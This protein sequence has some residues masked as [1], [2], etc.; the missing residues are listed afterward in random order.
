MPKLTKAEWLAQLEECGGDMS[1]DQLINL[2]FKDGPNA[3]WQDTI[4]QMHVKHDGIY[5]YLKGLFPM[6]VW[7]D[8]KGTTELGYNYHSPFIPFDASIFQ[9]S[10]LICDPANANECH[11]DYCSIPRGG[12]TNLPEMEMYKAGFK[13]DRI[14]IANIRTSDQAR[15]LAQMFVQERFQ[16]DEQV[17]NIFF[18][19]AVIRMLGHKTVLEYQNNLA[20]TDVELIPN[21]NPYNPLQGGRFNYMEPLFPAAG[22]LENILPLDLRLLDMYGSILDETRDTNNISIGPRG[23]RIYELWYSGDWW[24]TE[25]LDNE[26]YIEKTKYTRTPEILPAHSNNDSS[27]HVIGNFAMRQMSA[28][29]RFAESTEG[30]IS[31]VQ[32]FQ[33]TPVDSGNRATP[34]YREY[35]NAPFRLALMLG[36]DV[37][38]ILSRPDISTGIEGKPIMPITGGVDS[39]WIY[40]NDYDKECNPDLNMP[41]MQKRYEMGFK[42]LNPDAGR[43]W[44]YRAKQFRL[45][46]TQTC[47]LRP[48][49]KIVPASQ[50]CEITTIGCNPLN[51]PLS[52]NIMDDSAGFRQVKCSAVLCG[53]AALRMYRLVIPRA[54]IDSIS[55]DQNPLQSC[56]CGDTVTVFIGD[57]DGDVVKQRDAVIMDYV[58]PNMVQPNPVMIVQLASALTGA[59]CIQSI[60]CKDA[61][62]TLATVVTC[63]DTESDPSIAEGSVKFI[64]NSPIPCGVGDDVE[65]KYYSDADALLDTVVGTIVSINPLTM[66]YV[67]SSEEADWA[68]NFVENT[69]YI[70]VNCD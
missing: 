30:G 6:R 58:R 22:N 37:G 15:Q 55:P 60:G 69:S 54:S 11:T 45:R 19:M 41:Y 59:E 32:P 62:P 16:V 61:T 5:N 53:D 12:I 10:M 51:A 3:L 27:R 43:G 38:E 52:N 33:N 67:I 68:C 26:E 20:G 42:M 56:E 9:R 7:N 28:L 17:M 23:E 50:S 65:I 34:N 57:A 8:W 64:L 70:T 2:V 39:A 46:A 66:A 13:T 63:A 49:F 47:N 25:V 31:V 44:I 40:R 48:I 4:N 14:C 35:I 21:D 18:T 29:P 36:K 1:Q 24:R